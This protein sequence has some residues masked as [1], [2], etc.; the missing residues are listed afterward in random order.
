M[1]TRPFGIYPL[2]D[3]LIIKLVQYSEPHCT[4]QVQYG[5]QITVPGDSNVALDDFELVVLGDELHVEGALDVQG[6]G[7]L[8]SDLLNLG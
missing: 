2:F 1:N 4:G 5:I 7:N 3:P 8:L 6:L